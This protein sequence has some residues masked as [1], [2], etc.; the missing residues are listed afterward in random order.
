[1]IPS[2]KQR[3]ATRNPITIV[4]DE[5]LRDA[6]LGRVRTTA[7]R[8][9]SR[10][11]A[12]ANTGS[13]RHE[14]VAEERDQ[15]DQRQQ[16]RADAAAAPNTCPASRGA[17][18]ASRRWTAM[19]VT[20]RRGHVAPQY[21]WRMRR[22]K[23]S[24]TTLRTR[25]IEEQQQPDEEQ[26]LERGVVAGDLV[27]AGR[28]RGH[29][30]RHRLARARTGSKS[31][32]S[33]PT[34]RP[35][36]PRPSSRR[37]AREM[38]RIIAATMP[39]IAAGTTTRVAVVTRRAPEA[40]RRLPQRR[41][42]RP[43]SRPRRPTRSA[44]SSGCRPRS[45]AA[46]RLKPLAPGTRVWTTYGVD[47]R[48]REEPE[49]DARDAREDLEDR[50]DGAA[51]AAGSRTRPGRSRTAGRPAPR[52]ASRS[53]V[54]RS[55][56]IS[57]VAMS[58][59]PRRGNQPGAT[60]CERSICGEELD[61]LPETVR[62]M[63]TVMT[64]DTSAAPRNSRPIRRL[65]AP[66]RRMPA[67]VRATGAGRRGVLAVCMQSDARSRGGRLRPGRASELA[68]PV[69]RERAR[70]VASGRLPGRPRVGWR[71]ARRPAGSRTGR[72]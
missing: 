63:N 55:V 48:Q 36:S 39:E 43:A 41:A 51:H 46:A 44:G 49:D 28:E 59:M 34:R 65:A 62:M 5:A 52:S 20:D 33:R 72:S 18:P 30:R 24:P 7:A 54:T 26:A 4:P 9:G 40:V 16:Q 70:R 11:R 25:V 50:L 71:R 37:S 67:S 12:P 56:P 3:T 64:T 60:S 42:A 45:P 38:P 21:G 19:A 31:A 68:R 2:G 22:T 10:G 14:L 15:D 58:N 32:A 53:T 69:S 23:L 61:R 66:A 1:M 27:G 47:E 8:S 35:R 29:R 13:A 57:S 17:V 6:R